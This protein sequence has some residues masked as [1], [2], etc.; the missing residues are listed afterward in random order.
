MPMDSQGEEWLR[1]AFIA[2]DRQT[3]FAI[4]YRFPQLMNAGGPQR[5]LE[6]VN[7]M[8]ADYA[9][10]LY[11]RRLV[12]Q[13]LK[14]GDVN[15]AVDATL[16]MQ[17]DYEIARVLMAIA[18]KYSLQEAS[19]R[20][21]YLRALDRLKSD[22]EHARVLITFFSRTQIPPDLARTVLESAAN[23]KSDYELARVLVEI[24]DKKMVTKETEADYVATVGHLKSDYEHARTLIN[25]LEHYGSDAQRLGPVIEQAGQIK[26]DYEAARVL[27]AIAQYRPEGAQRDAYI[28][29]ANKIG[30]E[31]ERKRALAA[32]GYKPAAL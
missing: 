26:S 21:A 27:T 5:V 2:L 8:S 4:D 11:L 24:A 9:R 29:A 12:Q 32:I 10:S 3:A 13:D 14:T 20:T 25:Y 6:E 18:E 28:R 17:S 30:S 19:T 16:D 22:Y 7:A 1:D 15:G 31:Y 23:L